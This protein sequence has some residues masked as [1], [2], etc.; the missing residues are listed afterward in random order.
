MVPEPE[1]YALMLIGLGL[2]RFM[3]RRKKAESFIKRY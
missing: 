2:V 3:A 1:I